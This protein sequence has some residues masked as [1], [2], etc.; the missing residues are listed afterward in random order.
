M[1][2]SSHWQSYTKANVY[3]RETVVGTL[4]KLEKKRYRFL[5]ADDYLRSHNPIPI[6]RTYPLRSEPFDSSE[7]PPFFDNL[8]LEGWLLGRAEKL[9][10]IDKRNRFALLMLTGQNPIGAVSV[11]PLDENEQEV[12]P[13]QFPNNRDLGLFG[14]H[15]CLCESF[16]PSQSKVNKA[17]W[18]TTRKRSVELLKSR[19]LETF[20]VTIYGGAISGAQRK[21]LF[22]FNK[23]TGILSPDVA[24]AQFIIKP[25][26]MLPEL[27]A[28]EH[29][30]MLIAEELSFPVPPCILIEVDDVGFFFIICRFDRQ[31]GRALMVE[32]MGQ[33]TNK[34]SED[35]YFSSNERVAKAINRSVSA[36]KLMQN[37]FF[38]RL[39][40]CYFTGNSDMHLK[41]WSLLE[42]ESRPGHFALSPCYDLL[43]TRL[44]LPY[45][46]ADIG[47][48]IFGKRNNLQSSYF[49]RFALE[50]LK[51]EKRFV[52]SV[53]AELD[54]WWK[55][56]QNAIPQSY[57]S[58]EFQGRYLEIVEERL[59]ILKGE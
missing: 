58:K 11:V 26:G 21:G 31:K 47:L 44:V 27:P 28:N 16:G 25:D 18:G 3:L 35:K 1:S 8:I 32:D 2:N 13:P 19:P 50:H 4:E 45:E 33:L 51:L 23:K 37:D 43:N 17:F 40:F 5:Y 52:N 54:E 12:A 15:D 29:I 57:L 46:D 24:H 30:T 20:S 42:D 10:Q 36:V 34:T 9:F 55:V 7:L 14:V 38:R 59:L 41:N 22:A 6:A 53:F 49:R 48:T 56:V 39:V